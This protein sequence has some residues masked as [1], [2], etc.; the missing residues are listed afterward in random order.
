MV[1]RGLETPEELARL[2]G[3][4][5]LTA[6]RW[7]NL[8]VARILATDLA[9]VARALN[10]RMVWLTDGS[11]VP[12]VGG[13]LTGEDQEALAI[14]SDLEPDRRREWLDMGKKLTA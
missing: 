11:T 9:P 13:L 8:P 1:M 12:Q 14:L 3:V 5:T 2:A 4:S 7:M 10:V 6:R